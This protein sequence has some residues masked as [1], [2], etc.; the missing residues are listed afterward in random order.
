MSLYT[1]FASGN[2]GISGNFGHIQRKCLSIPHLWEKMGH[3]K[4]IFVYMPKS[5]CKIHI[6]SLEWGM[7][8]RFFYIYPAQTN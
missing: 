2:R 3:R 4:D 6:F 1:L 5:T 7:G 8:I